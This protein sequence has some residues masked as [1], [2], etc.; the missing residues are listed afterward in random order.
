MSASDPAE[1][2]N[3]RALPK[4]LIKKR[5]ERGAVPFEVVDE[6]SPFPLPADA[7]PPIDLY[8]LIDFI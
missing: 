5:N 7:V 3:V 2:L 1:S 6:S 8:I 4:V